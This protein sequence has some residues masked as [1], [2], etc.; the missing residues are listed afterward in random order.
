MF[1]RFKWNSDKF[2]PDFSISPTEGYISPG[3]TVPLEVTFFPKELSQDIRYDVS[4][5][6]FKSKAFCKRQSTVLVFI[7]NKS[8]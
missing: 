6:N 1:C 8:I 3:M 5:L 2:G 7:V 4:L